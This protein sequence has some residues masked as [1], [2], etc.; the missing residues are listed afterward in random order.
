MLRSVRPEL[1]PRP[2]SVASPSLCVGPSRACRCP[3][4]LPPHL[5]T[6]GG[7][8]PLVP[9]PPDS[10]SGASSGGRSPQRSQ[11]QLCRAPQLPGSRHDGQ[12]PLPWAHSLY[13]APLPGGSGGSLG[14][15]SELRGVGVSLCPVRP[16]PQGGAAPLVPASVT[17]HRPLASSVLVPDE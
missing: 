14:S 8:R 11:S 17:L 4:G 7:S 5:A 10:L 15:S 2:D 6:T 1:R 9:W 13:S 3:H 16:Q 12:H